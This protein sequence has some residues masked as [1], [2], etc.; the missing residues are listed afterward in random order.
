LSARD[1]FNASVAS[2]E[3]TKL[4]TFQKATNTAQESINVATINQGINP[5]RGLTDTQIASVKAANVAFQVTAQKA[6]HDKQVAI[7][8]ARD[9]L[10]ATGDVNPT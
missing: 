10:R 5:A 9:A 8:N 1:T 7:N 2:A 3:T 4:T 6:E